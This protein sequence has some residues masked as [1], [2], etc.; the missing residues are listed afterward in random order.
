M[1]QRRIVK[2]SSS[3]L[4]TLSTLP[5]CALLLALAEMTWIHVR[6]R[7]YRRVFLYLT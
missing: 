4:S 2:P 3:F 6:T 1:I 7:V 5:M